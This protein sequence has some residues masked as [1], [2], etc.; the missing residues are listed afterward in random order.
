MDRT[1][2]AVTVHVSEVERLVFTELMR[3]SVH[4]YV[5]GLWCGSNARQR[6]TDIRP[7]SM[8]VLRPKSNTPVERDAVIKSLLVGLGFVDA[9]D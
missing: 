8:S 3:L 2:P 9:S 4:L 5:V 6:G 7:V 1:A